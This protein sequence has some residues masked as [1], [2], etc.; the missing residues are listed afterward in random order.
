MSCRGVRGA[1]SVV[2]NDS[3]SI[4]AATRALLEQ[5]VAVNGL[6][7]EDIASVT[8]TATDDLNAEYP[9]RAARE[10]GWSNVPLL[11]TRE[12]AVSGSLPHCIR[13]LILWNTDRPIDQITH[14]YL[15]AAARLRP[16]LVRKEEK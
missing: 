6:T 4:I 14:V 12:M 11:C 2:A 1:T 9:A 3:Q 5:M 7:V 16:D 13:V 8:F 15:G 10:M